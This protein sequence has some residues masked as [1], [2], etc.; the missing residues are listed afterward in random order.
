MSIARGDRLVEHL[1]RINPALGGFSGLGRLPAGVRRP[2]LALSTDGVGTKL[3]IAQ[4]AGRH[5]TVGI[6]LVA[7]VVNDLI[8]CGARPLWFLDYLATGRLL[9]ATARQLLSG[10]LK[11]CGEAGCELIG[12]ETAEMP[13]LYAPGHYDL[14]G[15]GVGVVEASEVVD[16]SRVRSG[17][18]ILGLASS[19]L[20]S[21]GFSL[22]RRVLLPGDPARARRQLARRFGRGTLATE[23]LRPTRI[24]VRPI[25]DLLKR[26][27]IHAMAHV[28]GGGIPGNLPRVLPRGHE[29][30]IR[31][32]AW[33]PPPIFEEIAR[34][35]PVDQDEMF[36]VFNMGIGFILVVPPEAAQGVIGRCRSHRIACHT[37]GWIARN[38]ESRKAAPGVTFL[39]S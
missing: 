24:Y 22:V 36:R 19:G 37:L 11:G 15:F 2:L 33:P 3:L 8:T 26:F 6:D 31:R 10:V 7:M 1:Q 32:G 25:L 28:T 4:M 23:L 34:R 30:L 16:G 12:G 35:G 13:G 29:A 17:D 9:P 27:S 38:A 21:N 5:A 14:A 18:V 39:E 20:H